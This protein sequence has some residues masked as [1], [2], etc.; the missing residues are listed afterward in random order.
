[1]PGDVGGLVAHEVAHV[2]CVPQL[3][4]RL[5]GQG[6]QGQQHQGLA[7]ARLD[8]GL[9]VGCPAAQH[10]QRGAVQVFEQLALPGIP[11]LGAGAPDVGH[12]EQVQGREVALVAHA[13]G[14]GGDHVGVR[15]VLLLRHV[16]HGEVLAHQELDELGVFARHAVLAAEAPR[17]HGA[18]LRMVAAAPLADV[19]EQR[20]HEQHPGLVPAARELRAE[21]VLVRM[22][23]NEEA[24]HIA[25]HHEDVLVHGVGVEQVVLH[26]P[27]DAPERPEVAPEHRGLVHQPHGV[28]DAR[29]LLQDAQEGG[30]VHRVAPEGSVHHAARVVERAQRAR[31]E[32]LQPGG[33]LVEQEGLKDGVRVAQVQVVAGHLDQTVLV[34]K[35]RVD[36]LGRLRGRVQAFFDVEQQDLA[37]LRDRLGRPVVAP[38]QRLAGAQRKAR[39]LGGLRAVAKGF[40]HGGLQVEHQPVF[41]SPGHGVQACADEKQQCLVALDLA[42]LVRCGQSAVGQFVPALAQAGGARH[43]QD[44]VQVA[45]ATGRFLAVGLQRVRGVFVFGVALAHLQRLGHQKGVRVEL[46]TKL[47]LKACK[48]GGVAANAPCFEQ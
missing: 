45:Q 6:A 33:A 32:V 8:H 24:P 7:L 41:A 29:G 36:G 38:H 16:A 31:R 13:L 44:Q 27:D 25:Q 28:R 46:R 39:A 42:H 35:A 14:E 17:L 22:F 43:P 9:C 21:R 37:Q 48:Q 2:Q 30:A 12:G 11:H 47:V 18:D 26:L 19:V 15:Q 40:G 20:G 10:A 5:E 23:G 3:L 1:M 4:V 34:Q